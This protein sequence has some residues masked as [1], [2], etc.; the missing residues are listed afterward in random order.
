MAQDVEDQKI[1]FVTQD[2]LING[3]G[4]LFCIHNENA[5]VFHYRENDKEV[6]FWVKN[7]V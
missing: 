6:I 1:I 3:K 2:V 5:L 4:K 7:T